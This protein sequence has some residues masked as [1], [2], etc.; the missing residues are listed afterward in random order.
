MVVQPDTPG[1]VSCTNSPS[2]QCVVAPTCSATPCC[3]S[4]CSR[5]A[6]PEHHPARDAQLRDDNV[7]QLTNG[8]V[9][10]R[11]STVD[12]NCTDDVPR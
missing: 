12:L 10:T 3:G 4:R 2:R 5:R 11:A 6:A 1:D 7:V 9:L 8:W